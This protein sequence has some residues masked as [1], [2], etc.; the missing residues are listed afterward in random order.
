M[1]ERVKLGALQPVYVPSS[2]KVADGFAKAFD[3]VKFERFG[4]LN[5]CTKLFT[6]FNSP[7]GSNGVE[8]LTFVIDTK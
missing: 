3:R 2:E 1:D 7:R 8:Y 5:W 4:I 6:T